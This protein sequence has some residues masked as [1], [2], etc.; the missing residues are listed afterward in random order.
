M[1]HAEVGTGH[2]LIGLAAEPDG[3]AS[4]CLAALGLKVED[5]RARLAAGIGPRPSESAPAAPAAIGKPAA[6]AME[7]A[8]REALQ[9]AHP[10]I[11]TEHLL[12]G[13]LRLEESSAARVLT[14]CGIDPAAARDEVRRRLGSYEQAGDAART[15]SERGAASAIAAAAGGRVQPRAANGDLPPRPWQWRTGRTSGWTLYVEVPGD[16]RKQDVY[17]GMMD[18][19]ELA[20]MVAAALNAAE[21][22]GDGDPDALAVT[23]HATRMG[24][25][26]MVVRWDG[27][28]AERYYPL[29]DWIRS[30]Q[31]D[32]GGA[33]RR[34]IIV[35]DDWEEVPG[36]GQPKPGTPVPEGGR[37]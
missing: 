16:D 9:R 8:L 19:P 28:A 7:L 12:L 35:V 27:P 23:E 14:A 17:A 1:G 26:T 33:Y 21:Q 4:R 25:G 11:G 13:L 18:T 30:A 2:L 22:R 20:E 3:V 29:A 5:A 24:S 34:R 31:Q 10:Y 37:P 36:A 6:K 15:L 32:H